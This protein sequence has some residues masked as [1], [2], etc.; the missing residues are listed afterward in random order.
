MTI[1]RNLLDYD[2]NTKAPTADL[3]TIKLLLNS[4]LSTPEAKFLTIDIINFYLEIEL[5]NKQYMFILAELIPD[6]IMI[7]YNLYSKIHNEN[8]YIQ[9]NKGIYRLKKVV[10][11]ANQQLQ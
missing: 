9:I 2:G 8:I 11:L 6:E 10:A 5:K 7:K 4:A 3:V 1:G